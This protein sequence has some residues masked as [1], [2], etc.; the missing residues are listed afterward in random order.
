MYKKKTERKYCI[1]ITK[2]TQNEYMKK[3]SKINGQRRKQKK[4]EAFL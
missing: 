1:G 2:I 3:Y 4:T